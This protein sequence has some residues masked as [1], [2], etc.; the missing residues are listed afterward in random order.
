MIMSL[1]HSFIHLVIHFG[2]DVGDTSMGVL[3]NTYTYPRLS[4]LKTNFQM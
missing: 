3:H 2:D 4:N 1:D